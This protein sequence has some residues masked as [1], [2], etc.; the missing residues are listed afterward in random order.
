M[1]DQLW[2]DHQK[3]GFPEDCRG[4]EIGSFDLVLLDAEIAG[5]VSSSLTI[6]ALPSARARR[7][8]SCLAGVDLVL[9][10]LEGP[11]L[12]YFQRLRRM[13]ALVL[14]AEVS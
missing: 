5:H 7:L 14:E 12:I 1:I 11:S 6:G 2:R 3:E 8:A 13:A 10:H 9:E 4:S